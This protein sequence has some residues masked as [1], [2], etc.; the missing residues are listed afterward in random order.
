MH[1][2]KN[3]SSVLSSVQD[4]QNQTDMTTYI[5]RRILYAIPI[6]LGV[7]VIT[8]LL[9]FIVNNPDDVARMHLGTKY[10]TQQ[11]INFW[12]KTHGYD[13]PLFINLQ[14]KRFGVFTDTLFF[15]KSLKLFI[16]D[17]GQSSRGRNI[18]NDICQ[19]MW[20]SLALAIPTL[21]FGLLLNIAVAMLL[22]FFRA[23]FFDFWGV[24]ICVILMSISAMFYI[25]GGQYLF[26]K[27]LQWVPISGYQSGFAA[28]KFLILP[29]TVGVVSGIGAGARWYRTIFLEEMGKEY[30]TTAY[31]KGLKE[32]QI[33]FKHVLKNA[34]LPILTGIV[35]VIPTLFM[36]SLIMESFFGIP[37]LGSYTIDAIQQQDFEVVRTMVFLGTVFYIVGL[38]LTD[39]SYTLVDPRVRLETL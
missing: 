34:A 31:A 17:F 36:G 2:S 35:V 27:I 19:R 12:K 30:V 32:T 23:T 25:I 21:L 11:E 37:G 20:P 4:Y 33:L 3:T 26:G 5:I 16:F 10:I 29:I 8:F 18:G 7:N 13:K 14:Q 39:I 24:T 38:I 1:H 15:N 6:L 9:F 22:V 28:I